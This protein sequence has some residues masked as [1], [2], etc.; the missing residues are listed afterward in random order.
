MN[1]NINI[2]KFLQ[3][4]RAERNYSKH[5]L[6]AYKNDLNDFFGFLKKKYPGKNIEQCDRV[7]FRDYLAS[8]NSRNLKRSSVIRRVGGLRSFFKY[9]TREKQIKKNPFLYLSTPKKESRIPVFLTENEIKKLFSLPKIN[10][11]DRA[12]LELLYSCGLRV[13]ELAGLNTCDVGFIEGM[14][15]IW[16]K[17]SKER[18]VPVGDKCINVLHDYVKTDRH[19]ASEKEAAIFLN[20]F[21]RR[22]SVRG[23]HKALN[24]WFKLVGFEKKISPH[25]LRHTFATHLL[26]HGCDLRSVQEMLGHSSLRTTQIYTHVTTES[27]KRVYEKSHPRA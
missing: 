20:R 4:L 14:V 16:G 18:L 6:R 11:R 13:S 24:K 7:I 22:I 27:L 15:R 12:I 5:T 23:V 26:D 17:G 2:K 19:P 9:L 25:A 1:E 21:G 8:L 3:Y 10:L